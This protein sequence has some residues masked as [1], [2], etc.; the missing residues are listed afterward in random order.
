MV[1]SEVTTPGIDPGTVRLVAQRLNHYA[2]PGPVT[3]IQKKKKSDMEKVV[4][5]SKNK[6]CHPDTLNNT[7]VIGNIPSLHSRYAAVMADRILKSTVVAVPYSD[8][9][10][11]IMVILLEHT[12][13]LSDH[14][15]P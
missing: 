7:P 6:I 15:S 9:M 8:V 11:S 1:W 5:S 13:L 3:Y 14:I 4:K 2:T 10:R 12:M